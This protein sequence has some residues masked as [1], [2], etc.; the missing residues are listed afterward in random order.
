M[1]AGGAGREGERPDRVYQSRYRRCDTAAAS[2]LRRICPPAAH[3]RARR[4]AQAQ[5][6]DTL[7]ERY[8]RKQLR[9]RA[10]ARLSDENSDQAMDELQD[11]TCSGTC[12]T[13][14]MLKQR[15]RR[16][17]GQGR[18]S[19]RCT[20]Y[21]L[22]DPVGDCRTNLTCEWLGQLPGCGARQGPHRRDDRPVCDEPVRQSC[23][24]QRA[25]DRQAEAL[26]KTRAAGYP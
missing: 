21:F 12:I 26:L 19:R 16:E 15:G 11:A 14:R 10:T 13:T 20:G 25:G 4:H 9:K 3:R 8:D 7:V 1:T 2:S 18:S 24:L 22:E 6:I 23:S 5:R 17:P